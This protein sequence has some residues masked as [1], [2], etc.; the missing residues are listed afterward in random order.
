MP[1]TIPPAEWGHDHYSTLAYIETVCVD[2]KGRIN[3]VKM[4]SDGKTYPTRLREGKEEPDH[5][6]W[7]CLRDMEAA[8][9]LTF[10]RVD[11]A[12]LRRRKPSQ[13]RVLSHDV[14]LTDL[15][16]EVAGRLRTHKGKGG[17]WRDFFWDG[18]R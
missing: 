16:Y 17:N 12:E 10:G 3:A 14:E 4:R 18:T 6:D 5:S 1:R 9:L 2:N 13:V 7:D 8:G 15:G 11:H